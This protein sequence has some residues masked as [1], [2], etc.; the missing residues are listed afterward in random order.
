MLSVQLAAEFGSSQI[1]V[2]QECVFT[3]AEDKTAAI[4]PKSS[5]ISTFISRSQQ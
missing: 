1:N 2:P 4:K 5:K 3:G